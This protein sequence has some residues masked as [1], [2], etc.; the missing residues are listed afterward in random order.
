MCVFALQYFHDALRSGAKLIKNY[1][2]V[3]GKQFRR[4]PKVLLGALIGKRLLWCVEMRRR[5]LVSGQHY[6]PNSRRY[7]FDAI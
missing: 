1:A 6:L 7:I 5:G 3:T 2:Y 4:L